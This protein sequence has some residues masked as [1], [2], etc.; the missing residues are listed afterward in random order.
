MSLDREITA[1]Q[2]GDVLRVTRPGLSF[3]SSPSLELGLAQEFTC[4]KACEWGS[5]STG[6]T[7]CVHLLEATTVV[8]QSVGR[9]LWPA[10]IQG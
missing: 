9:S 6:V 10:A 7:L 1:A 5:G 4:A 8:N 3:H 2:G